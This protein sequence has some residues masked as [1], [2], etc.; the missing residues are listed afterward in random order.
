MRRIVAI[1]FT[2][3]L[4]FSQRASGAEQYWFNHYMTTDGLPSNTIYA[5]VQDKYNFIWIGTRDGICRFDGHNF[6]KLGDDTPNG[7][8]SG[9]TPAMFMDDSGRLWFANGNGAG[10]YD[11]DTGEIISIGVLDEDDIRQICQ[12]QS[13]NIWFLS[14]N[15][16]RYNVQSGVVSKYTVADYFDPV[17]MAADPLGT[18]WFTSTDGSLYRFDSRRDGFEL[19]VSAGLAQIVSTSR[20]LLLASTKSNDVILLDP[21]TLTSR[22]IFHYPEPRSIRCLMERVPGEYWIGT[23]TGIFVISERDGSVT[24]IEESE[25]DPHAISASYI[26]S[27]ATDNEGNVWAGTFYKGLN[28]WLNK[29][30]SYQ[31]YYN[32]GAPGAIKGNIVRTICPAP[33]GG[34]WVGT[35]DGYLNFFNSKT[36]EMT[37][38]SDPRDSFINIQDVIRVDNELWIATYGNGLFRFRPDLCRNVAHYD[39]PDNLIIR[40]CL[41][42]DGRIITGT[43]EGLFLY[44]PD[45]DSFRKLDALGDNFVH[46]LY[47]DSRGNVWVGTYG[48]GIW[49]LDKDLN[50]TRRINTNSSD[51]LKSN[52]ITS[53]LE[54]S[55]HRIWITTEGGG[56]SYTSTEWTPDKLG[57]KTLD[58]S[59]GLPNNVTC[60]IAEDREGKL[61][62]STTHGLAQYD[63]DAGLFTTSYFEE[64]HITVSQYSYGAAYSGAN[65]TIYMGTTD[66]MFAISPALLK[67]LTANNNLLISG[68]T[69]RTS[70]KEIPLSTP[71]HSYYGSDRIKVG[72]KD[73]STLEISFGAPNYSSIL[74]SLYEY[75]LKHKGTTVSGTTTDGTATFTG[76]E[77]GRYIFSAGIVGD[78]SPEA[79]KT[80][81]IKVQPP[82]FQTLAAK[83]LYGLLVLAGL[84]IAIRAISRKRKADREN[85]LERMENDKQKEIYDAKIRYF[86][87]LTHEIR[88][89]LSLIKMPVDKIIASEGYKDSAKEDMLTIQANTSRL[90]DLT[91]QLLDLRKMEQKELKLNFIEEDFKDIVRKS[92]EY[93]TASVQERH[94]EMN[95]E[96]PD[97]PMQVVCARDS[98]EKIL[99][100]LISNAIKYGK[101]RIDVR[102]SE[103]A[104][105]EKVRVTV[106]SNGSRIADAD[107]EK[108]F[109]PFYQV[110]MSNDQIAGSKGTGL[111]LP[112][113]RTLAEL[114]NGRLFVDAARG[115]VNSFVLEIPKDQPRK[116]SMKSAEVH[117]ETEEL[118]AEIDNSRHTV[119]V[120]EDSP[121]MRYYLGK[122]LSGEYNT[123]LASNGEEALK[124]MQ[125]QKVDLVISDIMMPVMDGC[126]LCNRIKADVELCHVP[127]ILLTAAVGVETRIETLR[128]GADGYIEKPFSIDLLKA[129]VSNLFKNKEIAFKQFTDSPLSHY[130]SVTVGS[131]DNEFMEKLH[132]EVMKHLSEQD[133]NIEALTSILGTSKSTLY[134]KIKA[135][136]GLNINEYIRLCRLKEAAEM[137][138]SQK[139][140]INEVAYLVG[141]SS[142]SYFTTSFQKQ[143]NISPS[144][145]VKRIRQEE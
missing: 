37:G 111:G 117:K 71:G 40:S 84:F 18:V 81:E 2:L 122:E 76:I 92:C 135:N 61:W 116:V 52:H 19:Q 47:Q 66:G 65:G 141:F 87:N 60:A 1:V 121:E 15:T 86:T 142:P 32:S 57:L 21:E 100:N 11:V 79:H 93:F 26:M 12:D 96:M 112:F 144:A 89:P 23:E 17:S 108:I 33:S 56:V 119:L 103:D 115:D 75:S 43:H 139:Y 129:N 145:F 137:L 73:I 127:V 106:D 113:A 3:S 41:L 59:D 48:R 118:P 64:S 28:L 4:M 7:L 44:E 24:H 10:A 72:Y 80:L 25:T 132:A 131:I 22:T 133:L 46:A 90:L 70:D 128:V 74:S 35:E 125:E 36:K 49:L 9:M 99:T 130:N 91:N 114:H 34:L 8:T 6:V 14:S 68:I 58:K 5:V 85:Q 16:Y 123:L 69:A 109:E 27:M 77:P 45:S 55:S 140:R 95:L 138:S 29:R 143:F 101:D 54:D 42:K 30:D 120:V 20:G 63:P 13:G 39:F 88:T 102:L 83:I 82:L 136:T 38:F 105:G 110:R 62:I 124:V 53:F 126:E 104:T 94:I 50:L 67:T 134:R 31:L 98:I 78:D 51:G 97:A 107:R